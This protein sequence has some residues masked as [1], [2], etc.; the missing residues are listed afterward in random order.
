MRARRPR[1]GA[2]TIAR[3]TPIWSMLSCVGRMGP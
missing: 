2:K 1:A 3:G